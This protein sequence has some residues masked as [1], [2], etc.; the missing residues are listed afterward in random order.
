M[1]ARQRVTKVE[2]RSVPSLSKTPLR[3]HKDLEAY[4]CSMEL[5][6]HVHEVCDGFP[7]QGRND[8]AGRM[9]RASESIPASIAEAFNRKASPKEFKKYMKAAMTLSSQMESHLS[10][11]GD[12]GYVDDEDLSKLTGG[13]SN[14]GSELNR[15][16]TNWS[17]Y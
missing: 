1:N 7:S 10:A 4:Q 5:L 13:Y 6:V 12:L 3:S 8:L 16:I 9:R 17:R 14:M 11:A 2:A 15:L